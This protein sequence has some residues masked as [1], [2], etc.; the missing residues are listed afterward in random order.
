[1]VAI[2]L[3]LLLL[4]RCFACVQ[5]PKLIPNRTPAPGRSLG[6]PGQNPIQLAKCKPNQSQHRNC[7][8]SNYLGKLNLGGVVLVGD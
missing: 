4:R 2:I 1:M 8:V 7:S 6:R 5:Y 3:L